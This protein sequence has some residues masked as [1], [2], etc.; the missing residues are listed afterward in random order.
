MRSSALFVQLLV[1]AGALAAPS[2]TRDKGGRSHIER[3]DEF[4]R[5]SPFHTSNWAGAVITEPAGTWDVIASKFVIPTIS[6]TVGLR[7]AN[8]SVWIGIDGYTCTS[9]AFK[10]RV[11]IEVT[12]GVA[13]YFAWESCLPGQ[14]KLEPD[15]EFLNISAGDTMNFVAIVDSELGPNFGPSVNIENETVDHIVGETFRAGPPLCQTDAIWGIEGWQVGDVRAF[16]VEFTNAKATRVDGTVVGPGNA[17]II[18]TEEN[19]TVL[20]SCSTTESTVTCS[21]F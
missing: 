17:I 1:A 11:G 10:A 5:S 4:I 19:G 2:P 14:F 12:N 18:N 21:F 7:D 3:R 8:I 9:A 15:P 20:S 6:P 16:A 13:S